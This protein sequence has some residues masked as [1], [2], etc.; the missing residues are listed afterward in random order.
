MI[1]DVGLCFV[2]VVDAQ[3]CGGSLI[4]G[5][6]GCSVVGGVG[7]CWMG[8]TIRGFGGLV[9]LRWQWFDPVLFLVVGCW[10]FDSVG[11]YMDFMS[12]T[13]WQSREEMREAK[14][15]ERKKKRKYFFNEKRER[16]LIKYYYFL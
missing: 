14:E 10:V 16:S 3:V 7:G 11:S 6:G 2:V 5:G 15:R 8:L 12:T 9:L 1:C 13:T 4:A